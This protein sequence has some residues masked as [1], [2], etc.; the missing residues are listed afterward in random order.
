MSSRRHMLERLATM[1]MFAAIS[2]VLVALIRIPMFLPF[3]EYDPADI[4]ILLGGI[5]F[6]PAAGLLLTVVVSAIHSLLF[7]PGSGIIGF[8]M[9][10]IATGGMTVISSLIFRSGKNKIGNRHVRLSI[11]LTAGA[12]FMFLSMIPMNLL[13]TPIY[14]NMS[15]AEIWK[16]FMFVGIIPFNF[17]KATINSLAAFFLYPIICK[18]IQGKI[19]GSK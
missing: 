8:I 18:A 11:A 14:T 6:G 5:F 10:V 19:W 15:A 1:S 16:Q 13:L 3:L 12:L 17:L 4:P 7:S 2:I 9:H